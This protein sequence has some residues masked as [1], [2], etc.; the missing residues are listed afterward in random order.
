MNFY[1]RLTLSLQVLCSAA[2]AVTIFFLSWGA[3]YAIAMVIGTAIATWY[4]VLMFMGC[5]AWLFTGKV[6]G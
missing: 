5:T 3:P 4:A 6:S 2:A 1:Y